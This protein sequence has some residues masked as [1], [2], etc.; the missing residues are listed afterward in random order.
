[1]QILSGR[2][3]PSSSRVSLVQSDALAMTRWARPRRVRLKRRGQAQLLAR[4]ALSGLLCAGET[5]N[6]VRAELK[7]V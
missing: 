4:D 5:I 6:S 3:S 7:N 1:M 2:K